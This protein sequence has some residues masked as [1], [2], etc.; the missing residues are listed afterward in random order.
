MTALHNDAG[1]VMIRD[2]AAT[3]AG[4]AQAIADGTV[5]GPTYAAVR[6]LAANVDTLSHWIP[7]DRMT[8]DDRREAFNEARRTAHTEGHTNLFGH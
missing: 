4:Q 2:L 3:I 5:I 6:L 1:A 8:A 7:D